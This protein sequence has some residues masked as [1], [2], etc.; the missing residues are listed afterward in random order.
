MPQEIHDQISQLVGRSGRSAMMQA[1]SYFNHAFAGVHFE[2]MRFTHTQ[3]GLSSLLRMFVFKCENSP[4]TSGTD[5]VAFNKYIKAANIECLEPPPEPMGVGRW[6]HAPDF[7]RV[8]WEPDDNLPGRIIKAVSLISKLRYLELLLHHF[9]TDQHS[10]VNDLISIMERW[11]SIRQLRVKSRFPGCVKGIIQQLVPNLNGLH[12]HVGTRSDL[13]VTAAAHHSGLERL[14]LTLTHQDFLTGEQAQGMPVNAT[15]RIRRDFK[16]L[17][18]LTLEFD[19]ERVCWRDLTEFEN[20]RDNFVNALK[21]LHCLDRLAFTIRRCHLQI[22]QVV[23]DEQS[24]STFYHRLIQFMSEQLPRI[25]SIAI[26][27]DYPKYYLGMKD[28]PGITMTISDMDASVL[29]R[30]S[31]PSGVRD[32]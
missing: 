11:G 12:L 13:Y 17:K 8:G 29:R 27:A 19:V 23:S 15:N 18:W 32:D 2:E 25:R 10:S 5:N 6:E 28:E 30:A 7:P 1:S 21:K 20:Q 14:H 31:W 9:T 24:M 3:R 22:N 16:S 4:S 26:R